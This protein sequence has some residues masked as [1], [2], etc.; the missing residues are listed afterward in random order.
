MDNSGMRRL[1]PH[2]SLLRG[3]M[4]NVVRALQ[5][6]KILVQQAAAASDMAA[7]SLGSL[8][9]QGHPWSSRLQLNRKS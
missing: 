7:L 3:S 6:D 5:P 2:V 1:K 9:T 4:A 8:D